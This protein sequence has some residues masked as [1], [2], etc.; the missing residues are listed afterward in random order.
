MASLLDENIGFLSQV[1]F[2]FP[3]SYHLLLLFDQSAAMNTYIK[4]FLFYR[5]R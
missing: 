5:K 1:Q 3:L 2:F 4:F